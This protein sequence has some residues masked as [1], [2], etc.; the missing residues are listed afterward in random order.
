VSP[1]HSEAEGGYTMNWAANIWADA[2]S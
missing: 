1:G 2:L